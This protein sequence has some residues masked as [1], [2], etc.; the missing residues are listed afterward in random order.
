MAPC[1][2]DTPRVQF[3]PLFKYDGRQHPVI[4]VFAFRVVEHFYILEYVLPRFISGLV[5]FAPDAFAHNEVEEAFGNGY[6]RSF[7][8]RLDMAVSPAAHGVFQN[9]LLQE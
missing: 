5:D 4:S 6:R 1:F 3:L 8:S 9:V 7:A 2:I